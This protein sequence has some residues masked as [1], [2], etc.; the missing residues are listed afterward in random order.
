MKWDFRS[1][2]VR[3]RWCFSWFCSIACWKKPWITG[4]TIVVAEDSDNITMLRL[5]LSKPSGM[6]S[7]GWNCFA[8]PPSTT[9]HHHHPI[10]AANAGSNPILKCNEEWSEA[11]KIG[12]FGK[13]PAALGAGS[14]RQHH[15]SQDQA[16]SRFPPYHCHKINRG[17]KHQNYT[18]SK[19]WKKQKH[20]RKKQYRMQDAVMFSDHFFNMK[21]HHLRLNMRGWG[22]AV[23]MR[24]DIDPEKLNE[25][26][27]KQSMTYKSDNDNVPEL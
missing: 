26:T 18:Q 3:T 9:I 21:E 5:L 16:R 8:P 23:K 20:F 19:G 25:L 2:E 24:S 17:P 1:T 7:L 10:H 4:V 6:Q 11:G 12:R 14:I 22:D 13:Q 15:S 27:N